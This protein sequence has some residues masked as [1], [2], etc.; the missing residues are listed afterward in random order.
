MNPLPHRRT[1]STAEEVE[2]LL[3]KVEVHA[4]PDVAARS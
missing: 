2:R 1:K 4:G 3:D